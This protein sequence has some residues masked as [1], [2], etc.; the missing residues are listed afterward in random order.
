[1][2]A[3]RGEQIA[4]LD[5]VAARFVDMEGERPPDRVLVGSRLDEQTGV[6]GEI[7]GG[8]LGRASSPSP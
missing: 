6:D 5:A 1:M 7:D 8:G 4:Q 3:G 2:G